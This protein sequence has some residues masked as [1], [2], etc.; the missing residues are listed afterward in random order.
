MSELVYPIIGII[1]TNILGGNLIYTYYKNKDLLDK[2]KQNIN[3]FAIIFFNSINWAIYSIWFNYLFIFL[4]SI[5]ILIGSFLCITI[6]YE[7]THNKKLFELIVFLYYIYLIIYISILC[8]SNID[9]NIKN[10][11]VNYSLISNFFYF[12]AP[13]TNIYN[14]IITKSTETL[15]LPFTILNLIGSCV[16]LVYGINNNSIF[17]IA[18]YSFGL[19][20]TIIEFLLIIIYNK[21]NI[22]NINW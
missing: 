5:L 17:Q 4:G 11:I 7:E 8:F 18:V 14:I 6:Y 15:Y 2:E 20:T 1:I 10:T 13:Y 16:W 3:I 9:I 21:L 22:I 19:M 12:I